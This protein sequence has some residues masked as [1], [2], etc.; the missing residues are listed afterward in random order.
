MTPKI[1]SIA[2]YIAQLPTQRQKAIAHLRK[3]ISANL[4]KGFKETLSYGMIGY[5]VPHQLYPNGYH[6]DPKLPLPFINLASQK[7]YISLYHMGLYANSELLNWFTEEY[8]KLRI[9]KLD[10]GK[11][12]IRFKKIEEIPYGLVGELCKKMTPKDWINRYEQRV[13]P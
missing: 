12:C 10:M 8:D 6:C 3:T 7:N 1:T 9:K 5:I 13:K 4:P 2:D 11:S